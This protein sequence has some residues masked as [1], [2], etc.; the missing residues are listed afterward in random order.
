MN[1]FTQ[2]TEYNYAFPSGIKYLGKYRNKEPQYEGECIK[3]GYFS[4]IF[5]HGTIGTGG[6]HLVK[7]IE[8]IYVIPSEPNRTFT[9]SD[10]VSNYALYS[11]TKPAVKL[12]KFIKCVEELDYEWSYRDGPSKSNYY[13]FENNDNNTNGIEWWRL[14]FIKKV[15]DDEWNN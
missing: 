11:T 2:N 13:H 1:T 3:I 8:K 10:K 9:E 5:E 7:E 4:Y 14:A 12:G 15:P 6:E